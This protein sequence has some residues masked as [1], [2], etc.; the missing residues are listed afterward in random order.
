MVYGMASA[1]LGQPDHAREGYQRAL[2]LLHARHRPDP[3]DANQVFQ[4]IFLLT[5]LGRSDDADKLLKQSRKDY[6][7][8]A[9]LMNLADNFG[10]MKQQ[11]TT[12]MVSK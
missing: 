6:P 9:Q 1:K 3:S 2:S 12:L 11:W 4:Q 8:D 10:A 7:A 5:L